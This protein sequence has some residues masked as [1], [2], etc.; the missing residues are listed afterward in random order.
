M[1]RFYVTFLC[2]SFWTIS[3]A[4]KNGTIKG[5]AFDTLIKQPV[6]NATVTLLQKKDS[7][8]F[9][10]T[11]TDNNGKFELTNIQN[12]EY[13][14]LITHVSYHN[15]NQ[16]FK[17]DD[18]HKSIDFGNILMNDRNKILSEVI[19]TNEAPPVTLVGDTIQYNAGSFKTQ[20]N[21]NVEDLLKK[22]PGVK[23]EK[24]GTVKAQG[25]KVQKVLVDGKEFFGN[26]PKIATK[27]L[28]A[29]AID[30]VQVFDKLSDQAQM[31]GFDD[32]NSEKTINL[33]LKKDKKKGMFGKINAGGGT[34][35]RYEGKFNMNSF[36]GARQMSAIGMGN[37]TNAEGFTFMD[38]LNFTGALNQLKT[39]G[40]INLTVGP[41]DP[42]AG[43]L[44]GNNNG[45]NTTFGGGLNY[46]DIIGTKTDFRSNYFYSRYNPNRQSKIQR[47][48]FSPAN[49]YRQNS[50]TD[51]LNNNHRLNFS[52]DYQID[53]FHSIKISPSFSYQKTK[54]KALSDYTTFNEQASKINE[55]LSDN[56]SNSEGY[57]LNT[58]ILFR[59]RF[60]KKARTFSLNV[61]TNLNSSNG[62]A[63]IQSLTNFYDRSGSF[64]S[65]DSINQKNNTEGDLKGYNAKAVYT[66]PIFK[67]SLLEFSLGSS[68]SKNISSKL[69]Y[70]Y[71]RN[72]GK[73]D[74]VND[75]LTNH[76]ENRYGYT[77]AGLRIRKQTRKYNYAVGL[78][79]QQSQLEGKNFS[80]IKDF[81]ITKNF[82]NFLPNGRFQYYF[83]R[84]KNILLNYTTNTNQPSISQLQP[85]PDNT[86]PL[87]VKLGN[88]N[89]K[90]EFI[91]NLRLNASLVN[92]YK[93]RNFFVYLNLQ[94]TQNKIVNYDRINSVGVDSVMP[95]NVNGVYNASGSVS[96]GFPVR[97]LKGS[98]DLTSNMMYYKGKQL[99]SNATTRIDVNNINTITLGPEVRLNTSPTDKIDLSVSAGLN[100]SKSTY[101]IESGRNSK[102]L[103]QEYSA[104][105]DWQLPRGLFLS[106]DFNYTITSQYSAGFNAKV[107]LWNASIAKQMLRF[108]RGELKF[109]V[110]D[111]LNKNVGINR[112]TNQNYIEDTRVKGLQRFFL[113]SFT[114][115]LSKTGL[116]N[117]GN[118]GGMKMIAH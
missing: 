83:A 67:K 76:F 20:P 54:N 14:L 18:Q 38:V 108:N 73:F 37:N 89:L 105:A 5:I 63:L 60:H 117:N 56:L 66:E 95:V 34:E 82:T 111:L 79:W 10:F 72:N 9:S 3:S 53:S 35:G 97:L 58:N 33:K 2:L 57:N 116:S 110:H 6:A 107:P 65:R 88:P 28:P 100:Y 39:G 11:M 52:A 25:E 61:L 59:K 78:S 32:G 16:V 96:W 22:L 94:E 21:A 113:L 51:N 42:L 55:G 45:I 12:G 48:Y 13:Q 64:L 114:Y 29:D 106:T 23:V 69:T 62:D 103:N 26:D 115:S 50:Y 19:V 7:S 81:T 36:K 77:N 91:Q 41:D 118:G 49:L 109:S 102:Y 31:T 74:L 75:Y 86:N 4:Q 101:S 8:L 84:S 40:N 104:E 47:E 30:K 68:L 1:R 98:I 99:I 87:Y 70:D 44:G 15:N 90:Q 27:N 24:D 85:V 43:L 71:N 17:I 80:T 93:N 46:N 92:P 112:S